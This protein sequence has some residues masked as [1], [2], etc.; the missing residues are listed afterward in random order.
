MNNNNGDNM[1]VYIEDKKLLTKIISYLDHKKISYTLDISSNYKYIVIAELNK[2]TLELC[3]N[4]KTIFITHL[5][6]NKIYEIITK[7]NKRV[8]SYKSNLFKQ[9]NRFYKIITSLDSIK[10]YLEKKIKTNVM[11]IHKEI[12]LIDYNKRTSKNYTLPVFKKNKTVLFIDL[13]YENP[14]YIYNMSHKYPRLNF[15]YVGFKYN[16]TNKNKNL[17]DKL[18]NN[19]TKIKYIDLN[20]FVELVKMSYVVVNTSN[21]FFYPDYLYSILL[22]KK[23]FLT[24]YNVFYDS[25][26]IG[27]KHIY[28]FDNQAEEKIKIDKILDN[29]IS[30]LVEEAYD[31]IKQNNFNEISVK[32]RNYLP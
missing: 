31:L 5:I 28:M 29:R 7:K 32:Y 20:I 12:P 9:L 18:P 22:L 10:I 27:S 14:D 19:V 23:K 13:D 15:L 17:I 21:L 2:K 11:V 25:F 24:K 1:L 26:L 8:I 16:P 3:E 4:K 30:N 6:E